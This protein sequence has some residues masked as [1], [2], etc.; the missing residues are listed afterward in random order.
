MLFRLK[1]YV[2]RRLASINHFVL[3]VNT[4]KNKLLFKVTLP[5]RSPPVQYRTRAGRCSAREAD[6]G[7]ILY[8][9]SFYASVYTG[10]Y[11]ISTF[12][13]MLFLLS[14]IIGLQTTQ[15]TVMFW[16]AN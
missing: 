15:L 3:G 14:V 16:F 5:L 2:A 8:C 6:A 1:Q 4:R 12:R 7:P 9:T 11:V 13:Y 10:L